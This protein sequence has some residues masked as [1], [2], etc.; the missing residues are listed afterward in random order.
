[1]VETIR[2]RV[3]LEELIERGEGYLYND[4]GGADPKACPVHSVRCP[5]VRRMLAV[6]PGPLGV[7]KLWSPSLEELV[8]ELLSL[9]KAFQFCGSEPELARMAAGEGGV[10]APASPRATPAFERRVPQAVPATKAATGHPSEYHLAI[11]DRV[12][13]PLEC[14]S[15]ARLS[16]EPHGEMR[17][18]RDALRA[19]AQGLT[20]GAGQVLEATYT[21]PLLDSVDAENVLFYNVGTGSFAG[22]TREGVRFERAF[23][24]CTAPAGAQLPIVEHHVGYRVAARSAAFRHWRCGEPVASWRG[25][26]VPPLQE[27][28]K[29][30]DVWLAMKRHAWDARGQLPA[31]DA[32]FALRVRITRGRTGGASHVAAM[33]K[34]LLDGIVTAMHRHDGRNLSD[35]GGRVA[36][37]TGA[38]AE[39]VERHLMENS[40]AVL[41]TRRLLW[42][43]RDSVQWN[44]ADDR[45]VA[46]EV[47]IDEAG[48]GDTWSHSG[49]L[50]SVALL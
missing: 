40:R 25:V 39:E 1:M 6:R 4:F 28:T 10:E 14:W 15:A 29:L 32:P 48:P 20:A 33:V 18:M 19:A 47:V 22:S 26:P 11:A 34:P 36:R 50:T 38:T 37:S 44:P 42:A 35:L 13:G 43:W 41:G 46:A 30:S 16:F 5:W 12:R 3:E 23:A 7:K 2:S 21:S 9:R 17:A 49:E 8:R 31:G 24:P 45:C 27:F